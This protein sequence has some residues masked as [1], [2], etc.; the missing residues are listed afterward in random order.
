MIYPLK[1]TRPNLH[2]FTGIHVK[3]VIFDEYV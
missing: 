2:V 1:E 3:H